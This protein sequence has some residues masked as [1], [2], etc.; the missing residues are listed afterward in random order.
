MTS[1]IKGSRTPVRGL[2]RS[3]L[4]LQHEIHVLQVTNAAEAW[5]LGYKS[6]GFLAR[7]TFLHRRAGL[8]EAWAK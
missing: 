6:V 3:V 7:Y 5:Q 1:C 8:D 2:V 4:R